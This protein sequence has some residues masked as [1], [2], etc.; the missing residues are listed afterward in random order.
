MTTKK[1]RR[2]RDPYLSQL[3]KIQKALSQ[4]AG[5]ADAYLVIAHGISQS[6]APQLPSEG[7]GPLSDYVTGLERLQTATR[8]LGRVRPE[9]PDVPL[10]VNA[11][12]QALQIMV[13]NAALLT[14]KQDGAN[15]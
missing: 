12:R 11:A 6:L 2:R 4:I 14:A 8:A 3:G 10:L 15:A 1:R 13:S 7:M 5:T 9:D